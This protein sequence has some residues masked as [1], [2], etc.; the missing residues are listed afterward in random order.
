MTGT[1]FGGGLD[2]IPLSRNYTAQ[3]SSAMSVSV[4]SDVGN[5]TPILKEFKTNQSSNQS[6]NPSINQPMNQSV[7]QSTPQAEQQ[8]PKHDEYEV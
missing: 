8:H 6:N 1:R 2:V 3:S 7:N 5:Q 4:A